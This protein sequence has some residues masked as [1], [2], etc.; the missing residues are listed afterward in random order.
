[1]R[2][3]IVLAA[4]AL[5]GCIAASSIGAAETG[6][7]YAGLGVGE[8]TNES[9]EFKGSDTLFK[10]VGGYSFNK[11]FAFEVA[12]VDAGTQEDRIGDVEVANES[13]GVIASVLARAPFSESVAV[14]AKLGYAFYDAEATVRRGDAR[15]SESDS[16]ESPAYGVGI[17]LAVWR[18]LRLR[19]EYELVDVNEGDFD[20]VSVGA[21]YKF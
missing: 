6:G 15:E 4:V 11:Y 3:A 2:K 8:A 20:M 14:F 13:S 7:V 17:E 21:V 18:G 5:A 16:D 1:M 10:L 12:Y 19:G 9:G